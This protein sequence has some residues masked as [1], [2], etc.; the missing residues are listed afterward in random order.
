ML[1]IVSDLHLTDGSSGETV[2]EGT[3]RVF[4]E[5]LRS[6]AYA[7]SWRA[8]GKYRPIKRLDIIL[9][10]DIIDVLRSSRWL[11]GTTGSDDGIRPWSDL[12]NGALAARV[13]EITQAALEKNRVFFGLLREI[14]TSGVVSVPA[15]AIND[16]FTRRSSG[17][18]TKPRAAVQVG[19]HYVAGNHDWYFHL[20]GSPFAR[21]RA[22]IIDALGL[23][24]D[25]A[26]PFPHDPAEPPAERIGQL[27]KSHRV[28]ARHGDIFDPFN[29]AGDRDAASLGD[30]IVVEL[31]MR[32]ALEAGRKF[33]RSLPLACLAAFNEIDNVRPVWLA[34]VWVAEL[35]RRTC[36]QPRELR[37]VQA[38]WNDVA[39]DFLRLP[40]V[41]DQ[42]RLNRARWQAAKLRLV[43]QMSSQALR[44]GS[45]RFLEWLSR[46]SRSAKPSYARHAAREQAFVSGAARYVVYG[47]THRHEVTVLDG[48]KG[49]RFYF[50]SGTWRPVHELARF[51]PDGGSF[52]R[53][54]SMT[55][56][57]FFRDDER[58]GRGFEA[59]S[60]GLGPADSCAN[61]SLEPGDSDWNAPPVP[62]PAG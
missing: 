43:L 33:R 3:L 27:L 42:L 10:G 49:G 18:A 9:L 40:F 45:R 48:A 24:N 44:P 56:L 13:E 8:G 30:A 23:A 16:E 41:R 4:R 1:V 17:P 14:K 31:L 57:A 54:K 26:E 36:S 60:G 12:A 21:I 5:R 52:A 55:Y 38:L 59:W 62:P 46:S 20:A 19:I 39:S 2:H 28:W 7:A 50:N 53:F 11:S 35:V 37:E 6:L 61:A 58:G 32:F 25:P 47:H 29:Y 51:S 34:P 22:H 15:S